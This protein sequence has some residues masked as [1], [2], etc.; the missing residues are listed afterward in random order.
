MTYN[1]NINLIFQFNNKKRSDNFFVL[2]IVSFIVFFGLAFYFVATNKT[3]ELIVDILIAVGYFALMTQV[4]P[5]FFEMLVTDEEIQV[6]FYTLFTVARN[7]QS[8]EM[9]LYQLKDFQI[10]SKVGGLRKELILSVESR[11]GLADY[12]PVSVSIVNKTELE[13]I[14][15]LLTQILENNKRI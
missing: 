9:K 11:F 12:P 2:F 3:W 5:S 6:N 1:E 14:K 13:R 4:R 15:K 7:Y 8:V 10:T